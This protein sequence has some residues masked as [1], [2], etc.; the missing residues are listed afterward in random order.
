M[1]HEYT[2]AMNAKPQEAAIKDIL[3]TSKIDENY[4]NGLKNPKRWRD[5]WLKPTEIY[6]RMMEVRKRGNLKPSQVVD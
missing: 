3:D 4:F 6:S 1:V 2:H 5:Y